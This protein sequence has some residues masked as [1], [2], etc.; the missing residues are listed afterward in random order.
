[1]EN[2]VLPP[3]HVETKDGQEREL[4]TVYG[5][6]RYKARTTLVCGVRVSMTKHEHFAGGTLRY[7]GL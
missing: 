4:G 1:M 5:Q 2:N 3:P 7:V 6:V